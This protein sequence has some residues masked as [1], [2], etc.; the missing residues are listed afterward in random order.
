MNKKQS[1][2]SKK[3]NIDYLSDFQAELTDIDKLERTPNLIKNIAIQTLESAISIPGVSTMAKTALS[4]QVTALE[5]IDDQSVTEN[6]KVIY[7]QMC[8]L[9]VSSLEATLKKYFE[10]ALNCFN[11]INLSN[12]DLNETKIT[13]A[14]LAKNKLSYR[15]GFGSLVIEKTKLNFQDLQ[16]IKRNFENYLS[17]RILLTKETERNI[18]FYLEARHVLVHKGGIADKKF[19]DATESFSANIRDYRSGDKIEINSSDWTN[20]KSCLL[21]LVREVTKF[22]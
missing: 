5:N 4:H 8:I 11:G 20:I 1:A 13:L 3:P 9:A 17:K 2:K 12:K 7:A 21:E 16:A 6:F 22:T 18:C 14:E 10:N 19:V 15:G